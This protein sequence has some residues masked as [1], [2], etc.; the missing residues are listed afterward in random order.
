[1]FSYCL[2]LPMCKSTS[3][4]CLLDVYL[5]LVILLYV[6]PHTA[7][8]CL[9]ALCTRALALDALLHVYLSASRGT[10]VAR[11]AGGTCALCVPGQ[12][13]PLAGPLACVVC[14]AGKYANV[15]GASACSDC[16]AGTYSTMAGANSSSFCLACPANS[17]SP[18]GSDDP[19]DCT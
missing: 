18:T 6:C 15:T 13:K 10:H 8:L 14:G 19:T 1:V 7:F 17:T 2:S 12:Y 9:C 11:S 5:K 4:R 16:S 3:V